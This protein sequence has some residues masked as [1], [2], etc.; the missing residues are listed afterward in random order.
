MTITLQA[1]L[2]DALAGLTYLTHGIAIG[3]LLSTNDEALRLEKSGQAGGTVICAARQTAGRG[4]LKRKWV[5]HEGDVAMSI[6]V[7]PPMVP[8]NWALL[9]LIPAV[10]IAD[11]LSTLGIDI[12]FKW[13]NDLIIANSDPHDEVDYFLGFRKVGG[14][15]VENAFVDGELTACIIGVGLNVTLHDD[16]KASIPHIGSLAHVRA[17]LTRKECLRAIMPALDAHFS[18]VA[19]PGFD[20]ALICAYGTR[21]ETLGR[22]VSVQMPTMHIIGR[23]ERLNADGSL[24]V[25]DGTVE[26]TIRAGDVTFVRA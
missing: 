23:A 5:L 4:R 21:C 3:E 15:L 20:E 26:H 18:S 22:T 12:R 11:G 9:S 17:H 25:I 10:A 7:R 19:K 6:I 8:R 14:I 13:P 16:D 2:D 24:V 1:E